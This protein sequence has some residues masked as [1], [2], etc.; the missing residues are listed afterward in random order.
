MDIV[1]DLDDLDSMLPPFAVPPI[2][3]PFRALAARAGRASLGG[4]RE[5][6][7][8]VL[9]VARLAGDALR[10]RAA[11]V[12]QR[13]ER[14]AAAKAWLASIAV[15]VRARPAL[16]RALDATAG[17]AA[18]ISAALEELAKV[19][20]AWLD[21]PSVAELRAITGAPLVNSG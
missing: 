15:P 19:A 21:D 7:M 1:D 8:A 18:A 20:G 13:E 12:K 2:R 3:F 5:V 4:E 14:A 6:A 11:E 17:D 16:G 9:M 10:P